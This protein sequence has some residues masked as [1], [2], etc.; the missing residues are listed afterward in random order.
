MRMFLDTGLQNGGHP[1]VENAVMRDLLPGF[2]GLAVGLR[3]IRVNEHSKFSFMPHKA[4][5]QLSF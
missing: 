2:V 5:V 1:Q 3:S 4:S